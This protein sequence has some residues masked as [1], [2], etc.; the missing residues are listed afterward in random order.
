MRVADIPLP[1]YRHIPGRNDRP[2]EAFFDAVKAE[3][4]TAWL[5]GMR[6]FNSGFYWEAHEVLEPVWFDA[7]PNSRERHLV[8]AIIHLAN[9]LLK[10]AMARPNARRRLAGLA[11]GRLFEVFPEGRGQ[12]MGID[13]AEALAAAD[14]LVDGDG[15]VRLKLYHEL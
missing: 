7:R 12:L 3:K 4:E 2:D 5:Y 11:R 15:A 8:Q 10:E 13:A 6:L 14:M 1:G 9:G